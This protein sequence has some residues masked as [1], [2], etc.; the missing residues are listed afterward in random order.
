M[1]L[2]VVL[3]SICLVLEVFCY[4]GLLLFSG[5]VILVL[6]MI[7]RLRCWLWLEL[8]RLLL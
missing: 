2:L 7:L 3:I 1:L 5:G 8:L 4:G 6:I